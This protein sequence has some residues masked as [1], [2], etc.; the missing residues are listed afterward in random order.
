MT[1]IPVIITKLLRFCGLLFGRGSSLPGKVALKLF[2]HVL[3]RI[4]HHG[5]RNIRSARQRYCKS[6]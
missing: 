6:I 5:R 4:A 1:A 3:S 2:T